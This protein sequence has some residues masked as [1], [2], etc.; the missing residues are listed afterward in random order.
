MIGM[1]RKIALSL[2]LLAVGAALAYGAPVTVVDALG[3]TLV[4]STPPRRIVSIAPSVTEILYAIG[5]QARLV[6]VSSADDYP[7]DVRYRP[8]VGG[9][10]LD[11]ERLASLRPDLVIGVASL[12]RPTFERL[13]AMGVRVLAIDPQSLAD[14][15][16]AILLIGRVVGRE[17]QARAV[18]AQMR[19]RERDVV[20]RTMRSRGIPR[21]YVEVWDQPFLTAARGTYVDDLL[22]RARGRN[23]FGDLEGWPQVSEEQILLRDPEVVLVLHGDADRVLRRPAWR[24]MRAVRERRVHAL[25]TAWVARPGP[26]L[27]LGLEQIARLLHP[28]VGW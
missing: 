10:Q 18:V 27:V 12:Q 5:A 7:P 24:S 28:E 14:T 11:F 2:V 6:G 19:A 13:R 25:V 23:I 4:F 16:G 8:K 20:L 17:A 15:Y 1:V 9:V 3:Q 21:V 26:R 22:R